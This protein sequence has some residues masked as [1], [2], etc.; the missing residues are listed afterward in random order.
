METL[1]IDGW[2][3]VVA[4]RE[5]GTATDLRRKTVFIAK[6]LNFDD[7][8]YMSYSIDFRSKMIFT[9]EAE[10]L[11]IRE[12]A[13]QFRIGSASV[14][15]WINQIKPKASTTHQRKIDKSELIKDVEQYPDAYRKDRAE[16]FG[17]CQKAILQALKKMGLTYKKLY[18]IRKPTKTLDKRFNKKTTV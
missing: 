6:R 3:L 13:K 16:R 8:I 10:G 14:S 2:K 1:E 18:V 9:M 17:V 4:Q 5:Q 15:R 11:S 12:T 7:I